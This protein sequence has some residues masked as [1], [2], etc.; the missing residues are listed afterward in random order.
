MRNIKLIVEYDGTA[1]AGWQIQPNGL[2]VQEV[3]EEA[4]GRML[5]E[6]PRLRSSGRTDAG[7]H[8][9]GMV[10]CFRTEKGMPLR[11][12]REGL[13]TLLPEDIAVRDAC[14]VPLEFNPRADAVAKHYRYTLLLDRLR[15][16]LVRH[17]SWRVPGPV[18]VFA[19][20]KAADEF[21]GEHDFLA[22]QG[23]RCAAKTTIRRINSFDLVREGGL[24]HLDINGTGFL[25]NM[26]RIMTGTL[27][28]VGLGRRTP[29]D[30]RRLLLEGDRPDAGIT[31][32]P[33]GLCLMEVFYPEEAFRMP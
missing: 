10:A 9:R 2:S 18:D 29:E 4:L 25:K 6:P 13:N 15:S 27:V 22:F 26:V 1:Y 12:F 32:P 19:M 3:M 17:S 24:L 11:A 30:I 31:A 20:E 7:V 23:A 16:P 8:A 5:G 28:E 21:V 14:E 33:Q